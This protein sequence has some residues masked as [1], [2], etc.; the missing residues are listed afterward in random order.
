MKIVDFYPELSGRKGQSTINITRQG[1]IS[2]SVVACKL[3]D[4]KPG[5]EVIISF[6][7][8]RPMDWFI[9]KG[10]ADAGGHKLV[11]R[12]HNKNKDA[13]NMQSLMAN[14]ASLTNKIFL[15]LKTDKKSVSMRI[16]SDPIEIEGVKYFPIITASVK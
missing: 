7:Q 14:C 13:K 15:H 12:L 1:V 16:G 3:I 11:L 4:I 6:D 10:E 8:D 2:V 5:D 9:R